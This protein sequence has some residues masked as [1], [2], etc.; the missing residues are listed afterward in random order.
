M[1]CEWLL[2][3]TIIPEQEEQESQRKSSLPHHPRH[4]RRVASLPDGNIVAVDRSKLLIYDSNGWQKASVTS[5]A[6]LDRNNQIGWVWGIAISRENHLVVVDD[7]R[8][9]KV[10]QDDGE[11][12]RSFST[13]LPGEEIINPDNEMSV[14]MDTDGNF[15]VGDSGSGTI[16]IHC[17]TDGR[18]LQRIK[19][20]MENTNRMVVN[21]KKEIIYCSHPKDS[22]HPKIVAID[23][24]GDEVF[25]FT[26]S[27]NEC[28]S[29][30]KVVEAGGI[31]CDVC[32]NIYVSLNV[33]KG[34]YFD[35][36]TGHIH[37]YSSAGSFLGCIVNRLYHP[38]DLAITSDSLSMIVANHNSILV[39]ALE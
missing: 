33:K 27:V 38:L 35:P 34:L 4:L 30:G 15:L 37:K 26:P 22:D 1:V 39:F 25:A 7:R 29:T 10:F 23:H 11:Y 3:K 31:I 28:V 9:A 5:P 36:Y 18:V 16:A 21:S 6:T 32:D 13:A 24:K 8:Y 20:K 19:C 12:V 14:A 2:A 17:N